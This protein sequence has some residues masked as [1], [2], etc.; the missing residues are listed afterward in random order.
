MLSTGVK[1]RTDA[2]DGAK[3]AR[4]VRTKKNRR[5][6]LAKRLQEEL[7]L[8]E[9]QKKRMAQVQEAAQF[10]TEEDWDTIWAKLEAN[11]D[12]VKEIA[13]KIKSEA[14]SCSENVGFWKVREENLLQSKRQKLKE[15]NQ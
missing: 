9:S 1:E 12:L 14:E 5:I 4:R 6:G 2:E 13:D 15:I 11:A 7:E 10:Y 8:S 3:K